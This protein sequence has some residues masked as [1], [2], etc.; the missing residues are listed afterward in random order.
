MWGAVSCSKL[1]G[2]KLDPHEEAM[3]ILKEQ[4]LAARVPAAV[5]GMRLPPCPPRWVGGAIGPDRS[6]L[7]A[8][9]GPK[10]TV[11]AVKPVTSGKYQLQTPMGRPAAT[12]PPGIAGQIRGTG[13]VRAERGTSS[14]PVTPGDA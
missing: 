1:F 10:E 9:Q 5:V 2:K 12:R 13:G 14:S 3:Q 8:S 4:L 7:S 11:A 6:L